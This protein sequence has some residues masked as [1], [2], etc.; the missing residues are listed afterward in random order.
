M[1]RAIAL[2]AS[3]A[4]ISLITPLSLVSTARFIPALRLLASQSDYATFLTLSGDAHPSVLFAGVKMSFTIFTSAKSHKS[5]AQAEINVSKLYRWLADERPNLFASVQYHRGLPVS[6]LGIPFKVGSPLAATVILK[7]L[8]NRNT[9]AHLERKTGVPML[10][11]R[12]VRHFVKAL[13]KAPYF[14]NDRDGEKKSEDYKLVYFENEDTAQLVRSFLVSSC[15][16]LFFLGLSDAYHC[17]RDLVL[18]FPIGL[19]RMPADVRRRLIKT[20]VKHENH[21]YAHSVRRRIL[22]KTTG[23]IEYDEF[24]PRE[25]KVVADEI[26]MMLAEHYSLTAE[27]LDFILNYDIKYRLGRDTAAEED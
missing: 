12:V 8:S 20:G 4:R 16:Y 17:G 22:Y 26:D 11:H 5:T 25:S 14:R 19:D 15:Y 9:V 10:Y 21:L 6:S 24:Y 1:E 18:S 2:L 13:F 27:E 23:W 3:G 7:L